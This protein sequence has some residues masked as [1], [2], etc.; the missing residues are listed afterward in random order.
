M[1]GRSHSGGISR[2]GHLVRSRRTIADTYRRIGSGNGSHLPKPAMGSFEL[3]GA[4]P[5]VVPVTSDCDGGDMEGRMATTNTTSRPMA[6]G[7]RRSGPAFSYSAR[8]S[9]PRSGLHPLSGSHVR[10]CRMRRGV[11]LEN[12]QIKR[13][14]GQGVRDIEGVHKELSRTRRGVAVDGC[15]EF[16]Q[17]HRCIPGRHGC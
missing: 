9:R 5:R 4:G 8:S 2:P 6:S 7:E 14:V 1:A 10:S 11:E 15:G 12:G 17:R 3:N 13:R 16:A